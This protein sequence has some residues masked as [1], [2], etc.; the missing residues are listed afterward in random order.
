[1]QGECASLSALCTD[2]QCL[3][4]RSPDSRVC[5]GRVRCFDAGARLRPRLICSCKAGRLPH[6]TS[7]MPALGANR[8]C[9]DG[10][11]DA[12]DPERTFA[13]AICRTARGSFAV[14][15]AALCKLSQFWIVTQPISPDQPPISILPD[16]MNSKKLTPRYRNVC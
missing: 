1:M 15:L 2:D 4:A 13:T 8:T 6:S 5:A 9:R 10:G 11:N 14:V 7:R 12:N 16:R 3:V